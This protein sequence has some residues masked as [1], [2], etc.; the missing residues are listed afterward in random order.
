[1]EKVY[2]ELKRLESQ[3]EYSGAYKKMSHQEFIVKNAKDK[4][5][6]IHDYFEWDDSDAAH[7]YRLE[8]ARHLIKRVKVYQA[9]ESG[10]VLVRAFVSVTKTDTSGK[11]PLEYKI[12]ESIETTFENEERTKQVLADALRELRAWSNKYKNLKELA[13]FIAKANQLILEFEEIEI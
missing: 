5:S 3:Y 7:K 9:A 1:M 8:Q 10:K 12:Y 2:N 4:E 13:L 11:E 6:P